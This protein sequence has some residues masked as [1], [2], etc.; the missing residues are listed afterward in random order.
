MFETVAAWSSIRVFAA[1]NVAVRS[2]F[3]HVIEASRPAVAPQ[4]S[5]TI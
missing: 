1:L 5:R 3:G 4:S 2:I